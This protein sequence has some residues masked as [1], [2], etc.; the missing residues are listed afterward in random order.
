MDLVTCHCRNT[1]CAQCGKMGNASALQPHGSD[2]GE[3][4]LRCTACGD[5]VS[6]RTGT[7]YAG[8][9]TDLAQYALGAKLLAEGL[10]VRAGIRRGSAPHDRCGPALLLA[11]ASAERARG[12]TPVRQN[13]P[14]R[15][16]V[17]QLQPQLPPAR[18]TSREPLVRRLSEMPL[19]VP[20]AGAVHAEATP[21]RHLRAQP[22]R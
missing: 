8:I 13:R 1:R 20:R 17:F 19:R 3:V 6:A 15:L 9:R 12:R 7:A 5:V 10:G 2:R 18:R 21:G 16:V 4:R 11:A 14:I 22:A